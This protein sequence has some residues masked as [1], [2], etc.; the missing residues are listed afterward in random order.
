[1][2]DQDSTRGGKGEESARI[3]DE[4]EIGLSSYV[5]QDPEVESGFKELDDQSSLDSRRESR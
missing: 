1:M 5:E 4:E 3:D 2:R